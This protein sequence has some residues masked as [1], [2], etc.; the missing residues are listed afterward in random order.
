LIGPFSYVQLPAQ[1]GTEAN[2]RQRMVR[3]AIRI[4]TDTEP[5]SEFQVPSI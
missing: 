5:T 2:T 3:E 1:A 4:F